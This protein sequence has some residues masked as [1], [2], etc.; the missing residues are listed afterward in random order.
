M[1][2]EKPFWKSVASFFCDILLFIYYFNMRGLRNLFF[3]FSIVA[4]YG[5]PFYGI[6]RLCGVDSQGSLIYSLIPALILTVIGVS[7]ANEGEE[8][9][10]KDEFGKKYF[11]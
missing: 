2:K 6:F 4:S 11:R 10:G 8:K 1:R 7:A 5:A 9:Y 3:C